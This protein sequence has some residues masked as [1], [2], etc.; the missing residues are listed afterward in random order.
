MSGLR[1]AFPNDRKKAYFTDLLVRSGLARARDNNL[2]S[3]NQVQ[4]D[5][6]VGVS[7]NDLPVLLLDGVFDAVLTTADRFEECQAG[8]RARKTPRP[9]GRVVPLPKPGEATSDSLVWGFPSALVEGDAVDAETELFEMA[10]GGLEFT[11]GRALPRTVLCASTHPAL[12]VEEFR[13]LEINADVRY[14]PDPWSVVAGSTSYCGL[15]LIGAKERAQRSVLFD[16]RAV[17]L[18]TEILVFNQVAWASAT[19]KPILTSLESALLRFVSAQTMVKVECLGDPVQV[20]GLVMSRVG[21]R[22]VRVFAA[23]REEGARARIELVVDQ[24]TVHRLVD[25]LAAIGATQI[26]VRHMDRADVRP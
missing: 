18:E 19:K 24:T 26:L 12:A 16:M 3:T 15:G 7:S 14:Y 4:L 5:R 11:P 20:Q 21:I 17:A 23:P 8:E 25:E 10:R 1:L 2:T 13:R 6:I 22:H 9:F